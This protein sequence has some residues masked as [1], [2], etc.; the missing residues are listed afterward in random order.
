MEDLK[1]KITCYRN[2][3]Y[4]VTEIQ[5]KCRCDMNAVTKILKDKTL[6]LFERK[7]RCF[8]EEKV[9]VSSSS[10]E[11]DDGNN[12]KKLKTQSLDDDKKCDICV[13]KNCPGIKHSSSCTFFSSNSSSKRRKKK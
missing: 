4:Q 12:S 6:G 5:K 2:R 11:E 8:K 10:D 13:K 7:K 3:N 9:R 1:R